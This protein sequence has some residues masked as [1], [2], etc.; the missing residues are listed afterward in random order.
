MTFA[1]ANGKEIDHETA[2]SHSIGVRVEDSGGES[3]LET[4]TIS[5]GDQVNES[6]DATSAA[7]V[8]ADTAG[9]DRV[10]YADSDDGVTIAND[11]SLGS[12]GFAQGDQLGGV[13]EIVGSNF[14]DSLSGAGKAEVLSGGADNDTISSGGGADQLFGDSGDDRLIMADGGFDL[15]GVLVDG[16]TGTDRLEVESATGTIDEI[17]LF[18]VVAN[19]EVIDLTNVTSALDLSAADI[20]RVTDGDNQLTLE[21]DGDDSI[22]FEDDPSTYSVSGDGNTVI[23]FSDDTQTEIIAELTLEAA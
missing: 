14:G 9:T 17:G 16:G 8:F 20:Q 3:L 18:D 11:N 4:F 10:S 2:A 21:I 13:D 12:G 15:T 1:V 7:E 6:F 23:F 5:I 22:N 19:V